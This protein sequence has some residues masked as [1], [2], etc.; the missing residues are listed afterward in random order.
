MLLRCKTFKQA[1]RRRR[2]SSRT[3]LTF[4]PPCGAEARSFSTSEA[5]EWF[6][7]PFKELTKTLSLFN[8]RLAAV[9]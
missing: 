5:P 9:D 2:S 7:V 1:K 8:T 6:T 3:L 4:D